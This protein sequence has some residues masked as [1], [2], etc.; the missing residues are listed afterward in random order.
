MLHIQ[1]FL[2]VSYI[3]FSAEFISDECQLEK[4]GHFCKFKV[5][6]QFQGQILFHQEMKLG[7]SVIPYFHVILT[8]QSIS[9]IILFIQGHVQCQKVSFKVK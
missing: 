1:Y 6:G 3:Y 7:T 2:D 8:G 5:K 4:S 9:K